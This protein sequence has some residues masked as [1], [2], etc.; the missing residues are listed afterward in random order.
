MT[1]LKI[2]YELRIICLKRQY[3]I[4]HL[5]IFIRTFKNKLLNWQDQL[6]ILELLRII[7]K[8]FLTSFYLMFH[9]LS[10]NNIL[11]ICSKS[12]DVKINIILNSFRHKLSN[13]MKFYIVFDRTITL[14]PWLYS[15]T[16]HILKVSL[17]KAKKVIM[18]GIL[19]YMSIKLEL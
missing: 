7:E 19:S 11:L 14:W 1:F 16:L 2:L 3:Q 4:N 5:W 6:N 15:F 12:A 10:E 9:S 8:R 17:K 18:T 13:L